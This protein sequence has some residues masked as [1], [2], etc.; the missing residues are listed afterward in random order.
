MTRKISAILLLFAF[1]SPIANATCIIIMRTSDG[2]IVVADT[3]RDITAVVNGV[4]RSIPQTIKKI[5]QKGKYYFAISGHDDNMLL[6]IS[7][8][9]IDTSKYLKDC[10]V[11]FGEKMKAYYQTLMAYE[12]VIKHPDYGHFLSGNSVAAVSFFCLSGKSTEL[13]YVEFVMKEVKGVPG[14]SYKIIANLPIVTLGI[15]DHM[16]R[17]SYAQNDSILRIT[18][19]PITTLEHYIRYEASFHPDRI[20]CP[21]D[22]LILG[23]NETRWERRECR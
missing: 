19:D 9:S 23:F 14:V 2:I 6:A 20:A 12:K 13:Y 21:L 15:H 4:R 7:M 22:I 10:V 11:G 5:H 17:L 3:R 16:D 1:L 8:E 18:K